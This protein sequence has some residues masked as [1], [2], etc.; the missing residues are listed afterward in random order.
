[1]KSLFCILAL[2][3]LIPSAVFAWGGDGHQLVALIA[4]D[5]LTPEAKAGIHELLGKD[6]HI[7]DGDVAS[8]ADNIRREKRS[9]AP[10]H[11]VDIPV[12]AEKFDEK[13]DGENGNNVIDKINDFEKVLTDKTKSKEERA[14]ALKY[15]V[16]FVGDVHQPLHCAN[17]N[18]DKGGNGRLVFFEKRQRAVSLHSVWDSTIL[19]QHKGSGTRN[20]SYANTLNAKITKKELE[21]WSMGTPEDWANESHKIA[22]DVVYKDVPADGN[23]PK[24]DED[25]VDKAGKVIDEQLE[26]GGVRL[27]ELLNRSL[28][29]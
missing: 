18:G 19:I 13:R 27:A 15:L 23:P 2:V 9:T 6:V 12:D 22:V 14:E 3:L 4:E 20:L 29:H 16:H 26:R 24:L 17:R 21:E 5:H 1:V 11:F 10:W 25:Y 7:S 8:W 28:G